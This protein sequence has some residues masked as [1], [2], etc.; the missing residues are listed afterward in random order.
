MAFYDT[1]LQI[2]TLSTDHFLITSEN[3]AASS[4]LSFLFKID[5]LLFSAE[6]K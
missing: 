4:V 5:K 3:A 2:S 6:S 1:K